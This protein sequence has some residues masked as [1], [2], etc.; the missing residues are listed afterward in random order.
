MRVNLTE[1]LKMILHHWVFWLGFITL[2]GILLRSLPSILNAAWGVDFGIYYGLTNSMIES[3]EL[4]NPYDGWG[5]SYQYFPVLYA[6][7]GFL[8]FITGIKVLTLMP[9]IAP[10]IGG[11][12]IPLYYFIAYRLSHSKKIALLSAGLLSVSTFHVYQTS[13]A[14]PLTVGHFF[15]MLSMYFF[16][17]FIKD[18]KYLIPLIISTGLLILSHHFTT[19]FYLISITFMLFY[20]TANKK[21]MSKHILHIIFYIGLAATL[22]FGYWGLIATPV[23]TSFMNKMILPAPVTIALFYAFIFGG[24]C[25]ISIWK[26]YDITPLSKLIPLSIPREKKIVLLILLISTL[27]I[28]GS[29]TGIPGVYV[30]LTPLAIVYS[31]PMIVLIGF[32][33]AGI[34]LLPT[35]KGEPFIKGWIVA[36]GLS[37]IYALFSGSLLPDRHLEYLIVPLCIPAAL[38]LYEFY[39]ESKDFKIWDLIHAYTSPAI[40]NNYK[41]KIALISV[42]SLLFLSNM[43]TAYPTINALNTLDERVSDPC[44]NC[45]EWMQGNISN[46]S[47]IASDHRISMLMWAEGFGITFGQTNLTWTTENVSDCLFELKQLNI[48]HIII[49][50]IMRENVINIDIGKY[51]YFT[52][53][54]YEKFQTEPF[55]LIYRNATLDNQ[56]LENHWVE[57]YKINYSALPLF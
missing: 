29:Y 18:Q 45:L 48:T 13:H 39:E 17:R 57:I 16:I 21:I 14:A 6:I 55:E 2:I 5:S 10:I 51:Y 22:A 50:D 53:E 26:K 32:A 3:K 24:V 33:L 12:T 7:T 31:I 9:K 52:N 37:F 42:I 19:Y 34:S 38:T 35:L 56:E 23:Y 1:N 25:F 40:L 27:A 20:Y 11:L 54:S 30:S 49:D 36:I 44:I 47:V 28:I 15:M 43:I 4:I 46:T 8:H 41:K